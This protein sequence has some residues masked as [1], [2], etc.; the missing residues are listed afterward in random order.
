MERQGFTRVKGRFEPLRSIFRGCCLAPRCA[1]RAALCRQHAAARRNSPTTHFGAGGLRR[2]GLTLEGAKAGG[3]HG[4]P[5][6]R[7]DEP[8]EPPRFPPPSGTPVRGGT[9]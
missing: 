4:P 9:R 3:H 8:D 1:V 5:A 2:P 7:G 6:R